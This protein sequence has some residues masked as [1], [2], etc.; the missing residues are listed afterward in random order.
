M[1]R[2]KKQGEED[3]INMTPMLDIVFIMLIFFIV[4]AS[5]VK[6]VGLDAKLPPPA[7]NKQDKRKA[8]SI[9][10]LLEHTGAVWMNGRQVD[11]RQI[12]ANIQRSMAEQQKTDVP[13]I[14]QSDTRTKNGLVI[15]VIDQAKEAGAKNISISSK[16]EQ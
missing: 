2:R 9:V 6:E 7:Q 12:S 15:R 3:D 13:V 4:T 14:I 16:K 1:L 10:I 11:V 8:T 5:F